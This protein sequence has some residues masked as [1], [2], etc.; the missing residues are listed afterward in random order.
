VVDRVFGNDALAGYRV[1]TSG[2]LIYAEGPR[3]ASFF[4]P[5]AQQYQL[6]VLEP[7]GSRTPLPP[8]PARRYDT[9][10]SPDGRSVAWIFR[11]D[12]ASTLHVY[13]I[14]TGDQEQLT[15][16]GA[17]YEPVW[18]PDSQSLLYAHRAESAGSDIRIASAAGGQEPIL[19]HEDAGARVVPTAWRDSVVL[20]TRTEDGSRN[21]DTYWGVMRE[22]ADGWS[23]VDRGAY[24]EA[25]W[26]EYGAA[27]DP[28]G[29][30][31][32][33]VSNRGSDYPEIYVSAF[34][35]PGLPA[36]G[37]T[38]DRCCAAQPTWD[39]DGTGVFYFARDTV[40]RI[41][42]ERER[43]AGPVQVRLRDPEVVAVVDGIN[44]LSGLPDGG[45]VLNVEVASD[46]EAG[47]SDDPDEP[48]RYFFVVNWK[49][50]LER[51]MAEAG[52]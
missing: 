52:R 29:E 31:V 4:S 40:Y 32:A 34:P 39:A 30:L 19:V 7:D 45:F 12:D 37:T 17:S 1:S 10:V 44:D 46:G 25:E 36:R 3:R 23:F 5:G 24:L 9:R 21:G 48:P 13:D 20:Y 26:E 11:D 14:A 28:T 33:L 42:V 47:V 38:R 51:K 35:D 41:E 18:S 15:F 27:L 43:T 16:E 2:E 50:E 49:A 22:T 6:V 8:A